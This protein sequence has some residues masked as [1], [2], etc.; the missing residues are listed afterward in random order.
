[1]SLSNYVQTHPQTVFVFGTANDGQVAPNF[2]ANLPRYLGVGNLANWIAVGSINANNECIT[3]DEEGKLSVKEAGVSW[4]SNLF[5]GS[6]LY[7]V[8][9]PG[10]NIV[11]LAANTNG[12]M[13]DSGTSMSTPVVSGALT[14]VAQAFPWMTGKQLADAVLTTA[15]SDFDA[16]PYTILYSLAGLNPPE[17]RFG[18]VRLVI[19]AENREK[20]AAIQENRE[21]EIDGTTIS[22]A[23]D[24]VKPEE[25]LPLLQKNIEQDP[26]AW[27]GGAAYAL[28]ALEKGDFTIEV[29]TKEE[30][31]GQG[32]LDVGKAVRGIARLDANRLTAA[33]V[34]AVSELGAVDAIETFDT[35]GWSAEFSNDISQR[36]WDDAY[37]HKD[38]HT[39]GNPQVNASALA[40]QG[41]NLGLLKTGAGT[42]VL[43][44]ENA[45]EGAT[46]V[47]GGVLAVAKRKDATGGVLEKSSVV[48]R[49]SGT[50]TGDGEIKNKLVNNGT[51][52]PGWRGSTLNAGSYEQ[53]SQAV[54]AVVFDS[55]GSHASLSVTGEASLDGTLVYMP[56][57]NLFYQSGLYEM[58]GAALTAASI[59]GQ[60]DVTTQTESPTL[61]VSVIEGFEAAL[62]EQSANQGTCLDSSRQSE[63]GLVI[64]VNR[65]ADAYSKWAQN[66][67]Q[68]SLGSALAA[69]AQTSGKDMQQ[70]IAAVDWSGADG[71]GVTRALHVLGPAAYARAG[72]SAAIEQ[73]ELNASILTHMLSG[74]LDDFHRPAKR[75]AL[76]VKPFHADSRQGI[77]GSGL[78][79][80]FDRTVNEDLKLGAHFVVSERETEVEDLGRT[81]SESRGVHLGAQALYGLEKWRGAYAAAGFRLGIQD[82]DMS[83]EAAF[84]GYSVHFKSD[85]TQLSGSAFLAAGKDWGGRLDNEAAAFGPI[86]WAEYAF[87][88]RPSITE[89][90]PGAA[91][92]HAQA[93]TYDSLLLSAGMRA[94][95]RADLD[96]QGSSASVQILAAWRH[97]ALE[98]SCLTRAGFRNYDAY[99][100]S[101]EF[102]DQDRDA[103]FMQTA[104]HLKV[105][106]NFHA[107]LEVGAEFFR[108]DS[109]SVNFALTLGWEF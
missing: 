4:F 88:K 59:K 10:S 19:I 89:K 43:S 46:I 45:Y 51:V 69:L 37:H 14:L 9:A 92:L 63:T 28:A 32:I 7:S 42:L 95:M 33:N 91:A 12:Y 16:P 3:K 44:G 97:E 65:A 17:D 61:D 40:L 105:R 29:L 24:V 84:T 102:A 98:D 87:V 6:E 82:S 77:T 75:D 5:R 30:V 79:A 104:L 48:V 76:W 26:S 2:P 50:L 56:Q 18:T 25:L 108:D 67:S 52:M 54:L 22:W 8:M 78:M 34:I 101:G 80:G 71:R 81:Q 86:A 13:I 55:K 94:H 74:R 31:F 11:S 53:G 99:A 47:E 58:K 62:V 103:L 38:F 60:I 96:D 57:S 93:A 107:G 85:W 83:R 41:K 64:E 100:F 36:K 109:S 23:S 20:A 66:S 49:E 35:N 68:A 39:D 106:E 1:M 73:N 70:L 27:I 21:I 72:Q 90:G 15:N